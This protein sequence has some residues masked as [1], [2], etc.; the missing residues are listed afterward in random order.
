MFDNKMNG[1]RYGHDDSRD[2]HDKRHG[3]YDRHIKILLAVLEAANHETTSNDEKIVG[4]D[5][6]KEACFQKL[7]LILF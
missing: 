1:S 5:V 4:E 2:S 7:N 3:G 6:S